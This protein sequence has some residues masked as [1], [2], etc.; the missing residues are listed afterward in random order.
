M[1]TETITVDPRTDKVV[2]KQSGAKQG[3]YVQQGKAKKTRGKVK[4]A[5]G[6]NVN[7]YLKMFNPYAQTLE[8]P[9]NYLGVKIPDNKCPQTSTFS[10]VQRNTV[11]VNAGGLCAIAHGVANQASGF[12]SLLPNNN[13]YLFGCTNNDAAMTV[14]DLLTLGT[15]FTQSHWTSAASTIPNSFSHVRLVSAGFLVQYQ[16]AISTSAGKISVAFFPGNKLD[17]MRGSGA[18]TL[19]QLEGQPGAIIQPINQLKSVLGRYRPTDETQWMFFNVA[20]TQPAQTQF[21]WAYPGAFVAAISGAAANSVVQVIG[22]YNYEGIPK[23]TSFYPIVGNISPSPIDPLA[24]SYGMKFASEIPPVIVGTGMVAD[25]HPIVN[26]SGGSIMQGALPKSALKGKQTQQSQDTSV[27][28]KI[29]S[30]L[31]QIMEQGSQ[32]AEDILPLLEMLA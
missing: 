31:P 7:R 21:P 32:F 4:E 10:L 6:K 14:G 29:M 13:G 12:G 3:Q 27:F 9:F 30:G 8:D 15:N 28:E 17:V 25:N 20:T 1:S 16:G 19:N 5:Y 2:V 26:V 24:A 23:D 11:T 22:I 18:L